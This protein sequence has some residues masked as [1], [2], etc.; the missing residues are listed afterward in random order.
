MFLNCLL[1][2]SSKYK[3]NHSLFKVSITFNCNKSH[4]I[5]KVLRH[6]D[7]IFIWSIFIILI[8]VPHEKRNAK[9]ELLC[10]F[11]VCRSIVSK[12]WE[13]RDRWAGDEQ[14]VEQVDHTKSHADQGLRYVTTNEVRDGLAGREQLTTYGA[15]QGRTIA[16]VTT[17]YGQ[18]PPGPFMAFG[19][20]SS[21]PDAK[22]M[23]LSD[24]PMYFPKYAHFILAR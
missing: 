2:K 22:G 7:F 5:S 9:K 19:E 8:L 1:Y 3:I 11:L 16:M 13:F 14:M 20:D 17:A 4:T 15:T 24:I 18:Y 6:V 10:C 23:S 12:R 21:V